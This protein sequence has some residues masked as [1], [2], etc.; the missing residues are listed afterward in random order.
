MFR[1]IADTAACATLWSGIAAWIIS[2]SIK[3]VTRFLSRKN[4]SDMSWLIATGGMPSAHSASVAAL[5]TSVGWHC[6]CN[7]PLFGLAV[8]I[9]I[10]TIFDAAIVRRATGQQARLLNEITD[11]LFKEGKIPQ[12]K[13]RELIGHTRLEVFMGIILGIVVA[14]L[15]NALYIIIRPE[16]MASGRFYPLAQ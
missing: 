2:Q 14:L 12:S 5:S 8:G 9:S 11:S 4:R 6:G 10:L 1:L 15:V 13:L 16:I 7:S 3:T